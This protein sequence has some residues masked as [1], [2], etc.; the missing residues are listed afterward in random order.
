MNVACKLDRY[1]TFKR[2][3]SEKE[4]P[5]KRVRSVKGI[6]IFK[7]RCDCLGE[8]ENSIFSTIENIECVA[9][10][11][12]NRSAEAHCMRSNLDKIPLFN[13]VI[14]CPEQVYWMLVTFGSR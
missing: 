2:D 4:E 8:F 7:F 12:F 10:I 1:V 9:I 3:Y 5:G 13:P 14:G 6:C 11:N